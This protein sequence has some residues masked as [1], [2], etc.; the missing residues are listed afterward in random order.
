MALCQQAIDDNR[1][2]GVPL[3]H[4]E[5]IC[6][7]R[8]VKAQSLAPGLL[9]EV[10]P[11]PVRARSSNWS[12]VTA[13]S[14]RVVAQRF[15]FLIFMIV[16]LAMLAAGRAQPVLIK[17]ARARAIDIMAPVLDALDRPMTAAQGALS[18]VRSYVAVR[19][20]NV[21]LSKDNTQ[22]KDWQNAVAMLQKENRELR[23]MLNFKTEP[24]LAYIS[25]RVIAD[26]GGPFTRGLIVT[27]GALDG[28]R[29]GMAA[30][31]GDGLVGRVVEVGDWS[32]RVL[33]MTDLNSRIPVTVADTGDRA[34]LAGD[35]SHAPKL[36]YLPQD[37]APAVGARVL[38]SG[39]GGIFPP[40]LPVGIVTESSRGN[41]T[42]AP[43]AEFGR[44]DYLRLV[45]FG[46]KGGANN[47]IASKVEKNDK[48]E[49]IRAK[50]RP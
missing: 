44:I 9:Q 27:A 45:D 41:V 3:T 6:G 22:L 34:I 26:T 30:M 49:A 16:A 25:A 50:G 46:L 23:A 12:Y 13:V 38:T 19:Q 29:E 7:F 1:E 17:E 43:A 48:L 24:G 4:G 47:A 8:Q 11:M 14:L 5:Q 10:M 15:S 42:V 39:H 40:N 37:A 36:F 20:E 18:E 35:N 2:D 33:L 21:R 31:T 28:V 32:S